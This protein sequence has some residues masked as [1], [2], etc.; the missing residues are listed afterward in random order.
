MSDGIRRIFMSLRKVRKIICIA[1]VCGTHWSL[2]ITVKLRRNDHNPFSR[3]GLFCIGSLPCLLSL[4]D[5]GE[6]FGHLADHVALVV[7]ITLLDRQRLH[8]VFFSML[9]RAQEAQS[10]TT[11]QAS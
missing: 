9:V 10:L 8:V 2:I 5:L 11:V 1:E 4:R 6:S 3:P 7:F